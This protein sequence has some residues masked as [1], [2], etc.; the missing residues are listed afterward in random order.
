MSINDNYSNSEENDDEKL[1]E[2]VLKILM[3]DVSSVIDTLNIIRNYCKSIPDKIFYNNLQAM[4]LDMDHNKTSAKKVG[5]ILAKSEYGFDSGLVLLKFLYSFET[6][7]KGKCMAYLLDSVSKEFITPM[8]CMRLCRYLNDISLMSL[9]YLK[10]NVSKKTVQGSIEVYPYIME[11]KNNGLMYENSGSG[12]S[13]ELD[14]FL[15][16]KYSLSYDEDNKYGS[17]SEK[18]KGIPDISSFPEIPV[19]LSAG[20]EPYMNSISTDKTSLEHI[21]SVE[22]TTLK[23]G[24]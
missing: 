9:I 19:Y 22:E 5:T 8:E 12:L 21:F 3:G 24:R 6:P 14:A 20:S 4:M 15:L 23:I 13:F 17:Y 1:F 10:N 7:Q 18:Y 16:D 2:T 11:L